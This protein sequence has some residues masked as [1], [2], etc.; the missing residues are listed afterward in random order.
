MPGFIGENPGRHRSAFPR[1]SNT[2]AWDSELLCPR[3]GDAQQEGYDAMPMRRTIGI[4]L[5]C[6][7]T[8]ACAI[9]ETPVESRTHYPGEPTGVI[10]G[11]AEATIDKPHS[12][13]CGAAQERPAADRGSERVERRRPSFEPVA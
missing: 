1:P 4:S 11:N 6:L 3:Q 10:P 8:S 7:V 2:I 12:F 9:A 13:T 5:A